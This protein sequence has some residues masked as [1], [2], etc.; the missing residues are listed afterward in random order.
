LL[1]K[2][3]REVVK[4]LMDPRTIEMILAGENIVSLAKAKKN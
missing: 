2:P 3:Q 1:T 4:S